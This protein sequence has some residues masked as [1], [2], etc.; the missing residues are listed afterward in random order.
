V[1]PIQLEL[2]ETRANHQLLFNFAS[3]NNGQMLYPNELNQLPELIK[4]KKE[5]VSVAYEQE[6][7]TDLINKKWILA[8]LLGLLAM[9]WLLRKR[10]GAY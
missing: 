8:L 9:E 1:S 10:N 6:T 3:E 2:A 4:N 7:L 5:I